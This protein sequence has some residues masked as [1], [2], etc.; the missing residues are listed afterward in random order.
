MARNWLASAEVPT[1]FWF[2][3][4]KRAAEVCNYF[5]IILECGTWTTPFELA[6]SAKLDLH[7]LSKLFSVAAVCR[8]RYGDLKLG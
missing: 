5:P 2:Y 8:E 3:A 6:H 7:V 1:S 4:V